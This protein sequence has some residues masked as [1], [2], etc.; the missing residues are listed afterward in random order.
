MSGALIP[1]P[2]RDGFNENIWNEE[3]SEVQ[4]EESYFDESGGVVRNRSISVGARD[5]VEKLKLK[6]MLNDR[7]NKRRSRL[8]QSK[9]SSNNNGYT[10]PR[11]QAPSATN[12]TGNAVNKSKQLTST[13]DTAGKSSDGNKNDRELQQSDVLPE[14]VAGDG[15]VYKYVPCSSKRYKSSFELGHQSAG[16]GGAKRKVSR[17]EICIVG[18]VSVGKTSMV[19]TFVQQ[20]FPD[21]TLVTIGTEYS[22]VWLMTD[23]E[24]GYMRPTCVSIVDCAG[25]DRYQ[26]I[27]PQKLRSPYGMIVVFD[28]TNEQS[29]RNAKKWCDK[30]NQFN[31][32]SCRMLVANKM[33]LY[34]KL[35]LDKQWMQKIDW[36]EAQESMECY[37]GRFFVSAKQMRG[38]NSM[39]VEMI[40]RAIE[41]QTHVETAQALLD[42][43]SIIRVGESS[44][45]HSTTNNLTLKVNRK[46][47]NNYCRC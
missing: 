37:E 18:D 42:D 12:S 44:V 9:P 28:A 45:S 8:F 38:I 15:V 40:D 35:P 16:G 19:A 3:E 24:N 31:Q 7:E 20:R 33:D 25:Q 21:K 1:R 22:S 46:S 29:F 47:V 14:E 34:E 36:E 43:D 5:E 27:L 6:Q 2:L 23:A 17:V 32:H 4:S 10:T 39:F 11:S 13:N 41:Q 30:I 26:S